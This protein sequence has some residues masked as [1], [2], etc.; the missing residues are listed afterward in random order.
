MV[1]QNKEE[2]RRLERYNENI[3][4]SIM[5]IRM[6]MNKKETAVQNL[7]KIKKIAYFTKK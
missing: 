2:L 1:V 5:S 7:P 4:N 3:I 6:N